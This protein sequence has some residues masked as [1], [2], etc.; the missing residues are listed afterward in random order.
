M[1]AIR[2]LATVLALLAPAGCL[3]LGGGSSSTSFYLLTSLASSDPEAL[4]SGGGPSIGLGPLAI[5]AYLDRPQIATRGDANRLELAEFHRWGEP[6]RDNLGRVLAENLSLLLQTDRVYL[7]PWR[8]S[9][10]IDYQIRVDVESFAAGPDPGVHLRCRWT[11][12]D[13]AGHALETRLS[14]IDVPTA[15]GDYGAIA[16]AMSRSAEALAR[17]LAAAVLA[18]GG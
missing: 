6:L 12:A 8:G 7:Y 5:P 9:A 15:L 14:R 10:S 1:R 17:E 4:E 3:S 18:R 13:A 16:E 2:L 11:L